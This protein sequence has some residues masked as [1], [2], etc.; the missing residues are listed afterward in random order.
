MLIGIFRIQSLGIEHSNRIGQHIIRHVMVADDEVYPFLLGIL[1]LLDG[2]D[3]AIQRDNQCHTMGSRIVDAFERDTTTFVV[4][5][6]DIIIQAR[7]IGT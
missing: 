6:R 2:L 1:N 5:I 3:A 7:R 4:A